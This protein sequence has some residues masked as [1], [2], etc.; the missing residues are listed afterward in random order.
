MKLIFFG[1]PQFVV[2][3]VE[4]I[5]KAFRGQNEPPIV[6][7]V[8]QGPKP[9][10]RKKE[11]Q[12]SPVDTWAFKKKIP[13][14]HSSTEFLAEGVVADIGILAAY[15]EILPDGVLDLFPRGILNIHPS[16]LPT[17]R[18]ASPIQATLATGSPAGAT[19]IKLDSEMD[20]GP[21]VAQFED[22]ILPDD[23]IETLR[24]RLFNR[25]S[26]VLVGLLEPYLKNKIT[27]KDQDHSKATY[28]K[29]LKKDHG[30]IPPEVL[31]AAIQGETFKGVFEI[32]FIRDFSLTPDS[33]FLERFI[34][35]LSLWP[36]AWTIV[37]QDSK[38]SKACPFRIKTQKR[39]KILKVHIEENSQLV[40]DQVQ[41]EGKQPVSW[42]LFK[43]GYPEMILS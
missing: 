27:L 19:I 32:P 33:L 6:A 1:T 14:Y 13:I 35:A 43:Q 41:L 10:G 39:L 40:L 16:L 11:L 23:T 8:T 12:Y 36:G 37:T 7:V 20:H 28:T 21:I 31:N 2:P 34:R 22:E 17:F 18:G 3:V 30:F 4:A 25:S 38:L 42:E 29:L 26:E 24:D 9:V 5:H 15:G